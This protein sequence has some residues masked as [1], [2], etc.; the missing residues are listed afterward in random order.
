M[1]FIVLEENILNFR[2]L[3]TTPE[4]YLRLLQCLGWGSL[5]FN[6]WKPLTRIAGSSVSDFTVVLNVSL[7]TF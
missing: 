5:I 4:S 6:G 3:Y 7:H 2:F 1:S